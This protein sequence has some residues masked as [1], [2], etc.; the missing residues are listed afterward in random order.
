MR[1]EASPPPAAVVGVAVSVDAVDDAV[2]ACAEAA[3]PPNTSDC[4]LNSAYKEKKHEKSTGK[5]P[6]FYPFS[7]LQWTIYFSITKNLHAP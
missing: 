5:E 1:A 6:N 7:S 4:R 2:E 3:L